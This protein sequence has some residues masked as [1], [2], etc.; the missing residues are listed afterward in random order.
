MEKE[1]LDINST[2]LLD[3]KSKKYDTI[4]HLSDS[5]FDGYSSQY[6]V[7][8]YIKKFLVE[9]E[10]IYESA[11][12]KTV[13]EKINK[14]LEYV[15]ENKDKRILLIITDISL[16][17]ILE[18]KLNNFRRG[19]KN[20]EL[21]YQLIDHHI[22]G[23]K[24]SERN[25]WY[26]FNEQYCAGRLTYLWLEINFGKLDLERYISLLVNSHDMSLE[27]SKYFHKGNYI[28]DLIF[29]EIKYPI[30]LER[31][32]RENI[33]YI[34]EEVSRRFKEGMSVF[35]MEQIISLINI[36]YLK[37]KM[38][39]K[40][41]LMSKDIPYKHKTYKYFSELMSNIKF[42]KIIFEG[43]VI[44]VIYNLGAEFQY[45]SKHYL[46][47]N[48]DIDILINVKANRKVAMRSIKDD[49]NLGE[50]CLIYLNG[51][52]HK[53]AAGGYL[54]KEPHSQ[55]EAEMIIEGILSNH[56]D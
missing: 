37:D 5:D 1:L 56:K 15:I 2:K 19:N 26:Y 32:K 43:K 34:I 11:E 41:F 47:N 16:N 27:D 53:K 54:S 55:D 35:E 10:I 25:E 4:L 23:I 22:S 42:K 7:N 36:N 39:D 18:K 20:I 30:F 46:R 17:E 49:V 48:T 31:Y 29:T 24:T 40:V 28:A 6:F 50:I 13:N 3:I 52:G 21:D 8:K 9:T 12:P 14:L 44:N 38:E 45:L 33:F 51:G